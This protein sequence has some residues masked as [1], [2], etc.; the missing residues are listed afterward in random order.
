MLATF[1]DKNWLKLVETGWFPTHPAVVKA[2]IT[3][4]SLHVFLA[5][6]WNWKEKFFPLSSTYQN[7]KKRKEKSFFCFWVRPKA[8]RWETKNTEMENGGRAHYI[9]ESKVR[10]KPFWLATQQYPQNDWLG[11]NF[12]YTMTHMHGFHW[13]CSLVIFTILKNNSF[14]PKTF[15]P[16]EPYLDALGAVKRLVVI[17]TVDAQQCWGSDDRSVGIATDVTNI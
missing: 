11:S 4:N 5:M 12:P 15:C 16:Q 2:D 6:S 1:F 10:W 13:Q 14:C 9:I 8:K 17:V 7:G 3:S